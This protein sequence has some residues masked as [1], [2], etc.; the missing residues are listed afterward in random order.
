[1][2]IMLTGGPVEGFTAYGPF[3]NPDA[4]VKWQQA[5]PHA[6]EWDYWILECDGP[7]DAPAAPPPRAPAVEALCEALAAYRRALLEMAFDDMLFR[8]YGAPRDPNMLQQSTV[9][10]GAVLSAAGRC[11]ADNVTAAFM[12]TGFIS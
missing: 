4:A 10:R 5:Q 6:E 8:L 3:P 9:A 12:A 7:A 1:M 2:V 11:S